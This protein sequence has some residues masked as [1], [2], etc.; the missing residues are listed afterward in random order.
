M[1]WY[2]LFCFLFKIKDDSLKNG[3]VFTIIAILL[4]GMFFLNIPTGGALYAF[5]VS[6][7][8]AAL[9]V[10]INI[11][12]IVFEQCFLAPSCQLNSERLECTFEY[13]SR[14]LDLALP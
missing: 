1:T 8:R 13:V 2:P 3:K 11:Q 12:N 9:S 7:E 4:I 5:S 14:V 6:S 10:P